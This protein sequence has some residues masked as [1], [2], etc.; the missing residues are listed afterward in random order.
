MKQCL[1][2]NVPLELGVTPKDIRTFL[3]ERLKDFDVEKGGKTSPTPENPDQPVHD[4]DLPIH[5]ADMT[6]NPTQNSIILELSDNTE[7]EK[8]ISIDGFKLLGQ[9]LRIFKMSDQSVKEGAGV[10]SLTQ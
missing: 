7:V 3:F 6:V 8:V 5:I 10:F 9:T 2:T 4:D 1:I